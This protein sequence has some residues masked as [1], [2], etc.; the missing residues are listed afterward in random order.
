MRSDNDRSTQLRD[1]NAIDFWRGFALV[2]ILVN[3][4]PGLY[5]YWFTH[6]SL[7]IS[8]A[9]D[10]FVFLA[11]WALR[12][13]TER[14]KTDSGAEVGAIQ[15]KLARRSLQIY[16]V[17]IAS[18]AAG[19]ALVT[20]AGTLFS[21]P[22]WLT[23]HK[24]PVFFDQ[25]LAATIGIFLLTYQPNYFD[26]LPLY[27]VLVLFAIGYVA[28]DRHRPNWVLPVA[29]ALYLLSLS[30]R[31][32][33]PT[34]PNPGNWTFNPL[35]WQLTYV[36]GFVLARPAGIGG[37]ARANIIPLRIAAIP[38]IIFGILVARLHW[39][40]PLAYETA[41]WPLLLGLSKTYAAP[42]RLLQFLAV[43]A[44]G[45]MLYP[46][47][48]RLLPAV[49]RFLS[50]LGRNSLYVFAAGIVI[51]LTGQFI[52]DAIGGGFVRDT[53]LVAIGLALSWLVA[54]TAERTKNHRR[55]AQA[56]SPQQ[57]GMGR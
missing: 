24:F 13:V 17:Q 41:D 47:I 51:S 12:L 8:D 43:I 30:L 9:A 11:G 25:P 33:P 2:T 56:A 29:I 20:L 15:R 55:A 32:V 49:V 40:A 6:T 37:W 5:V 36:L 14:A 45:S 7:S 19:L 54:R 38:I 52:R 31:L 10:L 1:P 27:V 53:A 42:L 34:W 50:L 23:W 44:V 22:E 46:A 26:I 57:S 21:H 35:A 18:V 4:V 16:I 48:A 39:F 28:L 3:H